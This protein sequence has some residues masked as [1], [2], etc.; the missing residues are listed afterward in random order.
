[1]QSPSQTPRA[2]V[3]FRDGKVLVQFL[4]AGD[5]PILKRENSK[6]WLPADEPFST[7][8][9]MLRK[10]LSMD[11][12]ASLVS[13]TQPCTSS[14]SIVLSPLYAF[15][16]TRALLVRL[17]TAPHCA[18]RRSQF[19]YCNSAFA[20]PPDEKLADVASCFHVDGILI[21]NYCTTP[22]WG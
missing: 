9:Q 18:S 11:S 22:A 17:T 5:A 4:H 19:L 21:L 7:A 13:F 16:R 12:D 15:T 6:F 2:K 20:P 8:T 3:R 10:V 14:M 1:M